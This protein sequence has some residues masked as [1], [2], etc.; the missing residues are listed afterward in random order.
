[1][2][3]DSPALLRSAP[4]FPIPDSRLEMEEEK[5]KDNKKRKAETRWATYALRQTQ[6]APP[7]D[8]LVGGQK[9]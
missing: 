9:V 7:P 6:S 2:R 4:R 1:M 5:E 8:L 3:Y